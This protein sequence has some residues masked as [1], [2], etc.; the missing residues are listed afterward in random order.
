MLLVHGDLANYH[1][2]HAYDC[3]HGVAG[4]PQVRAEGGLVGVGEAGKLYDQ[5]R[6]HYAADVPHHRRVALGHQGFNLAA[7]HP[8][9]HVAK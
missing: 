7:T 9:C 3:L 4:A 2:E 6:R 1:G 5:R 8:K